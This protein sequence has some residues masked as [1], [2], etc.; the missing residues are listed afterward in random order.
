[1]CTDSLEVENNPSTLYLPLV[2]CKNVQSS[3]SNTSQVPVPPT[4][5]SGRANKDEIPT[6]GEQ[7]N[8]SLPHTPPRAGDRGAPT[9]EDGEPTPI[10]QVSNLTPYYQGV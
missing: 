3:I 10:P 4:L 7:E 1:M 2:R 8:Q 9:P 5:T 6:P